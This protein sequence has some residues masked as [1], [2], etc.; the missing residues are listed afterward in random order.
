M[1]AFVLTVHDEPEDGAHAWRFE[2]LHDAGYSLGDAH[3]I[4]NSSAD[5][6]YA[7]EML[8]RCCDSSLARRIVL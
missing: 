7:V 8:R 5:L 3:A 6:H 1:E 2:Q 4:A